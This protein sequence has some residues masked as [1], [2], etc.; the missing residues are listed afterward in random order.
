MTRELC[1]GKCAFSFFPRPVAANRKAHL[2]EAVRTGKPV[3]GQDTDTDRGRVFEYTLYPLKDS[4]DQV[5][6][7]MIVTRDTT[8]HQKMED[9]L[10]ETGQLLD[11]TELAP[12]GLR[13]AEVMA[14]QLG[15]VLFRIQAETRK[16]E[17]ERQLRDLAG[18]AFGRAFGEARPGNPNAAGRGPGMKGY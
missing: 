17:Y 4:Q 9:A 15:S 18:K 14:A 2:A 1:R 5:T 10:R 6:L 11:A 13:A 8:I 12:A 7:A 16:R 3:H